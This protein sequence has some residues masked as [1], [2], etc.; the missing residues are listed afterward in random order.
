VGLVE[1][2]KRGE[3]EE[4]ERE[5]ARDHNGGCGGLEEI[6]AGEGLVEVEERR[7]RAHTVA[8]IILKWKKFGT[9][10]TPRPN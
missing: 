3:R 1:V 5:R 9:T 4:R 2:E 10:K 8:S 6:T 7:E